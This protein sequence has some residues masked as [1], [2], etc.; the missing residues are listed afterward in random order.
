MRLV[1]KA[2]DKMT[3]DP[4][5]GMKIK[6]PYAV[7]TKVKINSPGELAHG[8]IATVSRLSD[9]GTYYYVQTPTNQLWFYHHELDPYTEKG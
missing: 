3:E 8:R 4:Y 2:L 7:G 5:N 6:E 1:S 9:S